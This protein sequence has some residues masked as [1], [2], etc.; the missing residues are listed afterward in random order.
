MKNK[1]TKKIGGT[2][3]IISLL[4]VLVL[5]VH[6]YMVTRPRPIDP[7]AVVMA[8]IDMHQAIDQRD[9]DKITGYM[10]AQ[11]SV[12]H[13]YVNINTDKVVFTFFPAQA[14]ADDIIRKFKADLHYDNAVRFMP[15]PAQ[16]GGGCPA[17]YGSGSLT[18]RVFNIFK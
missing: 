15:T 11:A 14:S 3:G 8:R 16:L 12:N 4:L 6:I 5:G 9:A 13:T 10:D 2:I 7:N 17:G 18:A 1:M